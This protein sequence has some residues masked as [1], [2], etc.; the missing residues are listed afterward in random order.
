MPDALGSILPQHIDLGVSLL[1]G[2]LLGKAEGGRASYQH[3]TNQLAS[4]G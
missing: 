3:V 4:E 1:S 2:V